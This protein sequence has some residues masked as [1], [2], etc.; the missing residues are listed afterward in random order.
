M[1]RLTTTCVLLFVALASSCGRTDTSSASAINQQPVQPVIN[2][3]P[4]ERGH[5]QWQVASASEVTVTVTAP[6]AKQV[7]ILS[8]PEGVAQETEEEQIELKQLDA[9]AN[10]KSGQFI[11]QL[12]LASDFAGEVWAEAIYAD[13]AKKQTEVIALTAKSPSSNP[14][15]LPQSAGGS[16]GTDE[17]ARSD[18]LTGGRI[19]RASFQAGQ[20][21]IRLTI[22]LPAFVL[23]LWQNGTEVA[24]YSIGIGRKNFPVP[25]G[26][27][28][29]TAI[30]FNPNWI[31]PDSA[32]VRRT[33]GV[34][35]YEKI[36][37]DDPRNPLG[38]IK[39][40][41]GEGYLIHE[42]AKPSD[43]GRL[44]SH[45]CIRMLREDLFDLAEKIIGARSLPVTKPQFMQAKKSSERMVVQL[46]APLLVDIN[47]DSQVIEG[48]VLHLY[49]D[50][51]GRGAFALDSLRA[52]LQSVG[53]ETSN[54]ADSTLQQ[55]LDQVGDDKQYVLSVADIRQGRWNTG[56]V[57]PVIEPSSQKVA[58]KASVK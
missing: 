1:N 12:T 26:E 50:V 4:L 6:R 37:A 3:S 46:D 36:T 56:Q 2:I 43:I 21:D 5:G 16:I 55:M 41:L 45:G 7:L 44:T 18:K 28:E 25:V 49:P 40:P 20:S 29:A 35:P 11:T 47:Y 33:K 57:M 27:R 39:I 13:G 24:V 23:T 10:A 17:S 38:K 9:P 53:V 48:G 15:A 54:F 34:E 30:I 31:P 58:K 52:E 32:W 14:N 19:K 8:R 42:A 22:N 51:Y